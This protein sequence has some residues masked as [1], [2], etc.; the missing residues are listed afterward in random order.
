MLMASFKHFAWVGC[1]AAAATLTPSS[2]AASITAQLTCSLNVLS[3]TGACNNIGPFGTVK[4][5][6]VISGDLKLTVDLL[7]PTPKFRDLVL[8]FGGAATSLLSSD[9]QA[10]LLSPDGFG[11][12]PDGFTINP[13]DGKFDIGVNDNNGWNYDGAGVYM[14]TLSGG[15]G[16]D[17][18]LSDFMV[19]D[20]LGNLQVA[21]HIQDIGDINGEDCDGAD[22]PAPC[23]PG[24][25]GDGS[26]KIG[27]TFKRD[28]DLPGVP[29]PSTMLLMGGALL[30]LGLLK[31]KRNS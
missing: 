20:S 27:G 8:N 4:P 11:L 22:D 16:V 26:L 18:L 24:M 30:G 31:K 2:Q 7:N 1:L 25:E 17:L 12:T 15:G 14:T 28:G 23:V 6:E 10:I 19:L 3:S 29:E 9:G 21:I 5:E 13:Y